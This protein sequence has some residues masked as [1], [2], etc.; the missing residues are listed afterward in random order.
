MFK[1]SIMSGVTLGLSALVFSGCAPSQTVE[2]MTKIGDIIMDPS[3]PVGNESQKPSEVQITVYADTGA[4]RSEYGDAPVDVWVFQLADPDALNNAD[5][6]SLMENPEATLSTSYVRHIR[7][8][9]KPG[10][11]SSL[12]PFKLTENTNY[13]GVAVAYS[14]MNT[15]NWRAVERVS[16]VGERY[17]ILIPI[18]R[19]GVTVQVHR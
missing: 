18:T 10:E 14:D 7:K 19:K 17:N 15:A 9:V 6:I 13:I 12:V 11:S 5:F 2:A 4:N 3:L 16:A 8:Q 1:R